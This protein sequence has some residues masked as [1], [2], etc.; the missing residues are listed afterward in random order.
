MHFYPANATVLQHK[1]SNQIK[2]SITIQ[3]TSLPN[4]YFPRKNSEKRKVFYDSIFGTFVIG[5]PANTWE[6]TLS[7]IQKNISTIVNPAESEFLQNKARSFQTELATL[8]TF[9][10]VRSTSLYSMNCYNVRFSSD[11]KQTIS[12]K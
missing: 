4:Q 7:Q 6:S 8:A 5:D 2:Y 1:V 10:N 9:D 12:I 11:E 3:S